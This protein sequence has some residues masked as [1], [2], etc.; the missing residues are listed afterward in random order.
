MDG[1]HPKPAGRAA[2]ESDIG[3]EPD[4]GVDEYIEDKC[5]VPSITEQA[6]K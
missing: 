1:R 5:W 6:G 3:A 2:D 4:Y